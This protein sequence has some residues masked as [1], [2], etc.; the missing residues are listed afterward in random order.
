M[1]SGGRQILEE[2]KEPWGF[3]LFNFVLGVGMAVAG[4]LERLLCLYRDVAVELRI[5]KPHT[6]S[7]K[8]ALSGC[9]G[10]FCPSLSLLSLFKWVPISF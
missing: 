6:S 4:L 9:G 10:V 3:I 7:P 2:F 8:Q 1:R 5:P